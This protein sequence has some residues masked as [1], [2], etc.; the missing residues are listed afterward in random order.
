MQLIKGENGKFI[1]GVDWS[2]SLTIELEHADQ[3]GILEY[4]D[5]AWAFIGGEPSV[6]SGLPFGYVDIDLQLAV[7]GDL[8]VGIDAGYQPAVLKRDGASWEWV[9]LAE[10]NPK[11]T[12]IQNIAAGVSHILWTR[13]LDYARTNFP[14]H[15]NP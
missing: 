8:Y 6:T 4:S 1:A 12:P 2:D 3:L 15:C 9:R 14:I 10:G 7:S 5:G 11:L 13:H